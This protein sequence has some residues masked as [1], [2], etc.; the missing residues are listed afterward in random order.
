MKRLHY[1]LWLLPFVG[2]LLCLIYYQ[3]LPETLPFHWGVNGQANGFGPKV[4][5]FY[6]PLGG[7]G[8]NLLFLFL[9]RLDPKKK[10]YAKFARP[11]AIMQLLFQV[12]LL[13]LILL[14][15][16]TSM[17]MLTLDSG[18]MVVLL[19]GG[20]FLVLG[21][22]M[23]KFQ[24]NYFVGLKTPWTLAN[25]EVWDKTHQLGGKLWVLSGLL[26]M[27]SV[28]FPQPM[29]PAISGVVFVGLLCPVPYSYVLYRKVQQ[30]RK[31]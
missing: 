6:Y 7:I 17:G 27:L 24:S 1:L 26:M 21:N 31:K 2:L 25:E 11:Y 12:F 30:E 18:T 23:P 22:F 8:M 14:T 10:N 15:V 29:R 16:G 28:L 9:P 3:R 4:N 13:L 20:L 19:M 5:V